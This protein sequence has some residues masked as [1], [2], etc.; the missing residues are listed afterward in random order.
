MIEERKL[1]FNNGL[2]KFP[3]GLEI[4][5]TLEKLKWVLT[6]F[7]ITDK[8]VELETYGIITLEKP[9]AMMIKEYLEKD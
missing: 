5:I 6:T 3:C 9:K 8:I 1:I 2:L 7:K 4:E